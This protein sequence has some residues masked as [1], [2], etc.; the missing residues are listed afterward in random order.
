MTIPIGALTTTE[1][2]LPRPA[3]LRQR[4]ISKQKAQCFPSHAEP[5]EPHRPLPLR[6]LVSNRAWI[7]QR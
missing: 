4:W 7:R 2:A 3:S 5:T 6:W 1:P